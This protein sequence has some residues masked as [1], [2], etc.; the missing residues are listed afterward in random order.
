MAEVRRRHSHIPRGTIYYNYREVHESPGDS[1]RRP[2]SLFC[3]RQ[4]RPNRI[5]ITKVPV[6]HPNENPTILETKLSKFYS[7]LG[8]LASRQSV[9]RALGC[10][11]STFSSRPPYPASRNRSGNAEFRDSISTPVSPQGQVV[12]REIGTTGPGTVPQITE[13]T[14]AS[15]V[16]RSHHSLPSLIN[17]HSNGIGNPGRNSTSSAPQKLVAT[18]S[19][20]Q[21]KPPKPIASSNNVSCSIQLAEPHVY[22]SGFDHDGRG[23]NTQNTAAIL[24]GRLVL[25]VQKSTKIKAVTLSFY[26]KARTEWP[27]GMNLLKKKGQKCLIR[28]RHS[29]RQTAF[30]RRRETQISGVAFL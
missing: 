25:N 4:P 15:L 22:L 26:G 3:P 24:R 27:E 23:N 28:C 10:V 12:R 16:A 11:L 17:P 30:F 9:K 6:N 2:L 7:E 21:F 29:T 19:T 13:N 5:S 1:V 14:M 18:A 8:K 20:K